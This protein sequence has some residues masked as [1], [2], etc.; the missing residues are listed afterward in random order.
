MDG[1]GDGDVAEGSEG[2]GAGTDCPPLF[3]DE[4]RAPEVLALGTSTHCSGSLGHVAVAVAVH[5][6]DHDHVNVRLVDVN[7]HVTTTST[8]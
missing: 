7:D 6:S 5:V 1:D 2:I 3:T 8:C 4:P